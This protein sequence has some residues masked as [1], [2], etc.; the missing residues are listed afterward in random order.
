M[1]I[2]FSGK[3]ALVTGAGSGIGEA[4]AT[5]LAAS[6]AK[7]LVQDLNETGAARVVAARKVILPALFGD[8]RVVRLLNSVSSI[9]RRVRRRPSRKGCA[10][11]AD[12]CGYERNYCGHSLRPTGDE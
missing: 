1:D 5:A 6:G 11:Y 2:S 9:A 4:I 10:A 12:A 8:R 7:V 3:T